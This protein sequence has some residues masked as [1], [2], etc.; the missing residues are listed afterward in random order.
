MTTPSFQPAN[1]PSL[2][3]GKEEFAVALRFAE[4][5]VRAAKAALLAVVK[6]ADDQTIA[7]KFGHADTA[8]FLEDFLKFSPTE[9]GRCVRR[10]RAFCGGRALATGEKLAPQLEYAGEAMRPW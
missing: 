7:T 8:A 6:A 10:A 5:A 3:S 4:Q 1:D 9:A 2:L